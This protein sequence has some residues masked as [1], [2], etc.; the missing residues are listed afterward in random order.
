MLPVR[1][2]SRRME[3][4]QENK[5][6]SLVPF[7]WFRAKP[8]L[9]CSTGKAVCTQLAVCSYVGQDLAAHCL[10]EPIMVIFLGIVY[11]L[12][13]L[14]IGLCLIAVG[15]SGFSRVGVKLST[16]RRITGRSGMIVGTI[17]IGVGILL[18]W[19][20]VVALIGLLLKPLA[21]I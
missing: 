1:F 15:L 11:V 9:S 10:M 13:C 7:S 19:P 5:A 12:V 16:R 20:L 21:G 6:T 3:H 2:V 4:R 14:P 17:C 18:S 8:H